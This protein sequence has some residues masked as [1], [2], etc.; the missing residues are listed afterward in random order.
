[1]VERYSSSVQR[2]ISAYDLFALL[3]PGATVLSLLAG[4]YAIVVGIPPV[5][6]SL[7]YG[8]ATLAA[9]LAC[10][11]VGHCVEGAKWPGKAEARAWANYLWRGAGKRVYHSEKVLDPTG[12]LG[13]EF[14]EGVFVRVNSLVGSKYAGSVRDDRYTV[15]MLC[16]AFLEQHGDAERGFR[17]QTLYRLCVSLQSILRWGAWAFCLTALFILALRGLGID[18][19]PASSAGSPTL[20]VV[21]LLGLGVGFAAMA[22]RFHQKA[23]QYDEYFVLNVVRGFA[24]QA[25][26]PR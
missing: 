19:L 8:A 14:V 21:G 15:F 26:V 10:Y 18:V 11:L 4:W 1:M 23:G 9:L 20:T 24:A 22:G 16:S 17:M 5:P 7:G 6:E 13:P 12:E 3:V 2:H 25:A